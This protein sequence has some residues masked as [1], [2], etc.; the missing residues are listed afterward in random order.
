MKEEQKI[1]TPREFIAAYQ[2]PQLVC[3]HEAH[4]QQVNES[5]PRQIRQISRN[6]LTKE[7]DHPTAENCKNAD[8]SNV[9][10]NDKKHSD[11]QRA[12]KPSSLLSSLTNTVQQLPKQYL[13]KGDQKS[14][15]IRPPPLPR[16]NTNAPRPAS[17]S[18][19]QTT[20]NGASPTAKSN[21]D[22]DCK[23]DELGDELFSDELLVDEEHYRKRFH[24]STLA[25]SDSGNASADSGNASS[26]CS[27]NQ[28]PS[29][30]TSSVNNAK[31]EKCQSASR[32]EHRV[33]PPKG[34]NRRTPA[35]D[36]PT[37]KAANNLSLNLI[38]S[39]TLNGQK[40]IKS[41]RSGKPSKASPIPVE[42]KLLDLD[43]PFLL[44]KSYSSRQVIAHCLDVG[45]A[46][47]QESLE[48]FQRT[49]PSLLIPE[50]YSGI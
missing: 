10:T 46:A 9:K 50:S 18:N 32:C 8:K 2:L 3:I 19:G 6:R 27:E 39:S 4:L 21:T 1:F 15:Q 29:N 42:K 26:N 49:G 17:R 28:Y 38:K 40:L 35:D 44:Y 43:Q 14:D 30:S 31:C 23:D 45:S 25:S 20:P 13:K 7:N 11:A 47:Q 36:R 34:E 16:S 37:S 22:G 24:T 12:A 5:R 33:E 48:H 41:S